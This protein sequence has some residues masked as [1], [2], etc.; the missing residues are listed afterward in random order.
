MTIR[1]NT[2]SLIVGLLV[3]LVAA[4]LFGAASSRNEGVYQLSV[5]ANSNYVIYGR[6][7]TGTGK[8]ETWKYSTGNH[9][10]V[11]NLRDNVD[12]LLGIDA[13]K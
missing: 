6:V 3:G 8:V 7:H 2:K 5:A 9:T 13:E 10:S 1:L 12:I 4:C 11:P